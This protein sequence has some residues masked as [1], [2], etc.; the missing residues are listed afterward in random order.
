MWL[1]QN[2]FLV[3]GI[4][5]S[6]EFVTIYTGQ[7]QKILNTKGNVKYQGCYFLLGVSDLCHLV[8]HTHDI[9]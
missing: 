8:V 3:T 5:A 7:H 1:T 9:E 4:A 6:L 2:Y